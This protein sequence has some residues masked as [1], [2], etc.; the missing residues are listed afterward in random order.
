MVGAIGY[1]LLGIA[2]VPKLRIQ[3]MPL[4][5][6]CSGLELS[7]TLTLTVNRLSMQ[8]HPTALQHQHQLMLGKTKMC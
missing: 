1:S 3:G 5:D 6:A 7:L 4:G 8:S 2:K